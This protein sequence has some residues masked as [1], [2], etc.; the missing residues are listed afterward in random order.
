MDCS[1]FF[2]FLPHRVACKISVP[3]SGMQPTP[4]AVESWIL[5]PGTTREAPALDLDGEETKLKVGLLPYIFK[6]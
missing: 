4:P 5:S 6:K 1:L 3:P 2:F